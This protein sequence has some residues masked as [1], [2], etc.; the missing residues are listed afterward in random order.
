MSDLKESDAIIQVSNEAELESE[1]KRLFGDHA[2]AA[3]LG[4]RATAAVFRRQGVVAK[5]VEEI[6]EC[7]R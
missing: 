2:A 5:C 7:L 4:E 6:R 1:V 3:R